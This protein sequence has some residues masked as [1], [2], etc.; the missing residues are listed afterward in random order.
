MIVDSSAMVAVVI[1]EPVGERLL[2]ALVDSPRTL[3]SA[4]TY[5]ECGVVLDRRTSSATRRRFDQLLEIVGVEIAP[6]DEQQARLA[7]EAHRDFGRG[8]GSP[9]RLNLGDCFTYALAAATGDELL[10]VGDDFSHTDIPAVRY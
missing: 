6:L 8:S 10:F 1:D 9:A 5:V 3:M 2:S 7:R 4:A